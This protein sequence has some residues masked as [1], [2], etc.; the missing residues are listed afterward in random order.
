MIEL[1]W[2]HC[3]EPVKLLEF[4]R[5]SGKLTERK[6]RLFAVA[7]CRRIWPLLADARSRSA[8]D[9]A[10]RYADG[11]AS[12]RERHS[13]RTAAAQAAI[14]AKQAVAGPVGGSLALDRRP[15]WRAAGAATFAASG[16]WDVLEAAAWAS[17][18]AGE[19]EVGE[20]RTKTGYAEQE[21]QATLLRH[22]FK[23]FRLPKSFHNR[24]RTPPVIA[25][26]LEAYQTRIA[27]AGTLDPACIN[28]LYDAMVAAGC[29]E[30][31][32][33]DHLGGP[34]PHMPGCWGID[35]VLSKS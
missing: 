5:E 9:V 21:R 32:L 23:P 15:A 24:W 1:A 28:V 4:L 20:K 6:A 27:P 14:E 3:I 8:V 25:L 34:E 31:D 17:L 29:R 22:L 18:A 11:Q 19:E 10:E 26:A 33:L 16:G 35:L 30:V 2:S 7:C 12:S 13:A